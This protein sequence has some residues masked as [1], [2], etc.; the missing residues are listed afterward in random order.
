MPPPVGAEDCAI[1]VTDSRADVYR[2][3][4]QVE[5]HVVAFQC[6]PVVDWPPSGEQST[7]GEV[8]WRNAHGTVLLLEITAI[9]LGR[10]S[11]A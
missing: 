2:L 1:A 7:T 6:C 5:F 4:A 8:I 3:A 10:G 11:S 9:F